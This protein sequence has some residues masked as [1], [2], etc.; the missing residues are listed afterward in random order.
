L[1]SGEKLNAR[2]CRTERDAAVARAG[3][4]LGGIVGY[5]GIVPPVTW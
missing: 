5:V 4:Q 2:I 3:V 1:F